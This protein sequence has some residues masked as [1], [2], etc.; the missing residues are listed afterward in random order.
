MNIKVRF[1]I[2]GLVFILSTLVFWAALNQTLIPLKAQQATNFRIFFLDRDIECNVNG[3]CL[4]YLYGS[5]DQGVK[6]AGV[7]GTI[8]FSENLDI[9][10]MIQDDKCAQ[11]SFGFDRNPLDFQRTQNAGQRNVAKFAI[12]ANKPDSE[13]VEGNH[14]IAALIVQPKNVQQ[15]PA[16]GDLMLGQN[17]DWRA[18]GSTTINV[19]ADQNPANVTIN[20]TAPIPSITPPPTTPNRAPSQTPSGTCSRGPLGDGNCDDN[21]DLT[22]WDMGR[23]ALNNEGGT[24]DPNNDGVTN[25]LDLSLWIANND[26]LPTGG[27]NQPQ[28]TGAQPT[29]GPTVGPTVDPNAPTATPAPGTTTPTATPTPGPDDTTVT[30]T[31]TPTP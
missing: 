1:T 24:Y 5:S 2:L 16:Q 8:S 19:D 22:D 27:N 29:A 12:G 7:Q 23:S 11:D 30:N 25:A 20:N 26:Y 28:P 3:L 10:G 31:P 14:C 15:V 9:L 21:I 13:L 18:G 4:A 17:S 6:I